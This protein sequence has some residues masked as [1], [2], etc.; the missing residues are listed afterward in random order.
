MRFIN[1]P[2]PESQTFDPV[3]AGWT[4]LR[5]PNE[6]RFVA[7]AMLWTVP[8]LLAATMLFLHAAPALRTAFRL[9]SWSLP[10]FLLLLLGLVP[11][12]EFIH[13][14][15]YGCGLRSPNLVVGVWRQRGIPYVLCDEPLARR[16]VLFM[17]AAPFCGLTLLPLLAV[18]FL[19]EPLHSC[20]FFFS[21]LHAALCV[22]DAAT[23]LRLLRQAPPEAR[24]HNQGWQTYWGILGDGNVR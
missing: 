9:Q 12:H 17:L 20:V 2:I 1:G 10:S 24:V 5:A 23:F 21:L 16:R 3:A 7:A 6:R 11:A 18:P 22:G 8:F 14:L 4:P 19:S 15:A 13:A